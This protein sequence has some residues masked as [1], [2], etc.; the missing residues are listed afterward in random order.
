MSVK[1]DGVSLLLYITKKDFKLYTRGD[2]QNGR[3]ITYL[4]NYLNINKILIKQ[5]QKIIN[6]PVGYR[7]E[8][9]LKK[10]I[11]I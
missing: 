1:L 6:K 8:I 7:G 2:G 10:S 3:D 11:F 9:V 4:V 5:I